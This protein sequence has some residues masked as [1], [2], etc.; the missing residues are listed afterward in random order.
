MCICVLIQENIT[1]YTGGNGVYDGNLDVIVISETISEG[2]TTL[3]PT[4]IVGEVL[5]EMN[6]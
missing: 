4:V 6:T 3:W 1:K 5:T 2:Q